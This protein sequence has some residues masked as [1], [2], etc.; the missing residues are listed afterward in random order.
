VRP[1]RAAVIRRAKPSKV[2]VEERS[3]AIVDE[4]LFGADTA[5]ELERGLEAEPVRPKSKPPARR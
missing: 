2:V 4:H 5:L 1:R 3:G